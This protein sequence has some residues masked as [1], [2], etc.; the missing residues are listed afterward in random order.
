MICISLLLLKL[1]A[2]KQVSKLTFF[3]ILI[4]NM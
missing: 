1:I 4:K 2:V 3:S